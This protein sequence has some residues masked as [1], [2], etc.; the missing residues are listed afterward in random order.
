MDYDNVVHDFAQRTRENLRFVR[1]AAQR[2]ESEPHAPQVYEVTQLINSMLGLLVFPQ[3]AFIDAIPETPLNELIAQGWPQIRT[4][5]GFED[6]QHLKQLVRLLRNAI[7]HFNIE[8]LA[9][10]GRLTGV[11]VWN[12]N[13]RNETTWQAELSLNDLERITERFTEMLL[14][15]NSPRSFKVGRSTKRPVQRQRSAGGEHA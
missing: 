7:A 12:R 8:F 2:I 1:E 3:Q 9:P 13:K 5:G 11:R 4:T 15:Q 6:I 10:S 14:S